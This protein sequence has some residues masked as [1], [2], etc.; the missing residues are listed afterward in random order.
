M[1]WK[2][3]TCRPYSRS[4]AGGVTLTVKRPGRA[5]RMA[6]PAGGAPSSGATRSVAFTS[7]TSTRLPARTPSTA[8]AAAT[9]DLPVPPLPVTTTRRRS[10]GGPGATLDKLEWGGGQVHHGLRRAL[11]EPGREAGHRHRRGA[12]HQGG[13]QA[14][15]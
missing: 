14:P 1:A 2:R 8:S 15:H 9:V 5:S 4:A 7:A 13:G 3:T 11:Q 12:G 6:G 10:K